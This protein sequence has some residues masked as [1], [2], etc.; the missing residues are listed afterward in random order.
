MEQTIPPAECSIIS[1][2]REWTETARETFCAFLNSH[3]GRVYFGV[4]EDASVLGV[5]EPN[6]S[7]K[8]Q[9]HTQIRD[10]SFSRRVFSN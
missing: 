6:D 10:A 5:E 3:G 1:F 4:S 8:S 9:L 7:E 2:E